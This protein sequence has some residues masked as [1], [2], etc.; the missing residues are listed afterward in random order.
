M[1]NM[2]NRFIFATSLCSSALFFPAWATATSFEGF[3]EPYRK[4]EVAAAETGVVE[5]LLVREGDRVVKGQTLA[6]LESDVLVVS[7]EI[8]T[9]NTQAKGKLDFAQA[10]RDLRKR[11]L[12]RLEPLC[13]Q[14]N[15]SQEEIDRARTE[16]AAAEANLLSAQEQHILDELERKKIEAMIERRALRSPIDGVVAKVHKEEQEYVSNNS[17]AVATVVQLDPLRVVFTIPTA[18]AMRFNVGQVIALVFPESAKKAKGTIELIAPM[19]EAESGTTRVK[20]I[21][22]NPDGQ[23]RCGVRCTLDLAETPPEEKAPEKMTAGSSHTQ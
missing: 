15:A 9:A 2:M 3:T 13:Q 21:V 11:R 10:E 17:A 6:T 22:G 16:L 20:V 1:S 4:I 23:F 7:K 18:Y 12:E 19:T 14:G 8:A 5:K